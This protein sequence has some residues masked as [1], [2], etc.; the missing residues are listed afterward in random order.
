[1]PSK[2]PVIAVRTNTEIIE[3]MKIIACENGRSI[4]KETELLIKD[5]IKTYEKYNGEIK[6]TE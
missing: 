1:M 2:K 3:K 6:T 5:H 4:S